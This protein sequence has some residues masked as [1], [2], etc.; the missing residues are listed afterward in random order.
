MICRICELNKQRRYTTCLLPCYA[1]WIIYLLYSVVEQSFGAAGAEPEPQQPADDGATG[2]GTPAQDGG[3][4]R[5]LFRIILISVHARP[6]TG[7]SQMQG[8]PVFEDAVYSIVHTPSSVRVEGNSRGMCW[9]S[10]AP[11]M[12][13]TSRSIRIPWQPDLAESHQPRDDCVDVYWH[14]SPAWKT[15]RGSGMTSSNDIKFEVVNSL[16]S[17]EPRCTEI[18][19]RVIGLRKCCTTESARLQT[20]DVHYWWW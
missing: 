13:S 16:E 3:Q 10:Y 9:Y 17:R 7:R 8:M 12:C 18:R 2:G 11:A 15:R 19:D 6:A 20:Y 5:L 4:Y 14:S 1:T